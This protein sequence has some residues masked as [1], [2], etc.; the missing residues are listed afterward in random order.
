MSRGNYG[1]LSMQVT[2]GGWAV[3]PDVLERMAMVVARHDL[4]VRLSDDEVEEVRYKGPP[5][6]A[7]ARLGVSEAQAAAMSNSAADV[8][9]RGYELFGSVAVISIGGFIAKYANQV[10][11][12]SQPRGTSV[13]RIRRGL[14]NAAADSDVSSIL[15]LIDSPGG[16]VMGL[17]ELADDIAKVNASRKPVEAY[18]DD[19]MASAAYYLGSQ[20][21][22]ITAA[23]SSAV[24]SIGVY[25]PVYDTSKAYEK[26]G[27]V[28]HLVKAGAHKAA[29]A[30]GP[31]VTADDLK[32]IQA[33]IDSYYEE[34]V[35]R[36]GRGRA[37]KLTAEQFRSLADGRVHVGKSAL[38]VGLVD[39]I[40]PLGQVV[41]RM[42]KAYGKTRRPSGGSAGGAAGGMNALADIPGIVM[43][44]THTDNPAAEGVPP[45]LSVEGSGH[46][47][48]GGSMDPKDTQEAAGTVPVAKTPGNPGATLTIDPAALQKQISET[49]ATTVATTVAS[50]AKAEADRKAA[51]RTFGD[52][53]SHVPKAQE[54]MN[55]ALGDS[56]VSVEAFKDQL[57]TALS[58]VKPTNHIS[59]AIGASGQERKRADLETIMVFRA[60]PTVRGQ[61]ENSGPQAEAVAEA[62]GFT[63]EGGVSARTRALRAY[64]DGASNGLLSM[65]I[66]D[67]AFD[68]LASAGMN[69]TGITP[70][71]QACWEAAI[72]RRG[73][74]GQVA[75]TT[76][77]FP[78][79]LS[80]V[81][82]KSKLAGAAEYPVSWPILARRGIATDYKPQYILTASEVA[83]LLAK[84]EG[85]PN[86]LFTFNERQA[87]IQVQAAGRSFI[88]TYEMFRNDDTGVFNDIRAN[89]GAAS[90]RFVEALFWTYLLQNSGV[91]PLAP[92]GVAL[93]DAAH[94][95]LASPG[96][97][98]N[99]ANLN[100]ARVAMARQKGFG[101]DQAKINVMPKYLVVPPELGVQA[102]ELTTTPTRNDQSNASVA[103]YFQGKMQP[104]ETAWIASA[105]QWMLFADPNSMPVVQINFLDGQEEATIRDVP[106]EDP[107]T[108][109]W[110]ATLPGVGIGCPGFEGAYSNPGA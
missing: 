55:K 57:L 30:D 75:H 79:F 12:S 70:R 48:G 28:V 17:A 76:S 100:K 110:D 72:G 88:Y 33:E 92:D 43:N 22:M 90:P 93:F 32:V 77:D 64:K 26:E 11:G 66:W 98:L 18:A 108:L 45:T 15:L 46:R 80:N 104:V 20:A 71:S 54:A 9:A 27:I 4:G 5:L 42:D 91:G 13:D 102:W 59:V 63:A 61:L 85:I 34:F 2:E 82:K 109:K 94:N 73:V 21:R 47:P 44:A 78:L 16:S 14:M 37:S 58:E 62:L 51:I 1:T 50:Q 84:P 35:A 69:L 39:A 87:S 24:G 53:Y 23:G 103:N 40:A 29:G 65:S 96:T 10:N 68:S 56:T 60:C 81:A 83:N 31:P 86:K 52:R 99:A 7:V 3:K 89:V 38:D 19:L 95:N 49:V 74:V 41:G 6:S 25:T 105:T 36:A 107:M 101:K 67:V 106:S 8:Q 97:A